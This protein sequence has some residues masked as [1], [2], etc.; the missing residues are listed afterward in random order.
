MVKDIKNI[1][2]GIDWLK[3]VKHKNIEKIIQQKI[4]ENSDT[5]N[6]YISFITF[7]ESINISESDIN[8]TQ[9]DLIAEACILLL[10]N[11][12]NKEIKFY[13]NVMKTYEN[14]NS[15]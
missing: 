15:F 9:N 14:W 6:N 5:F 3:I 11:L 8:C 13:R 1:L 7:L 4:D 12:Y 10:S 2:S